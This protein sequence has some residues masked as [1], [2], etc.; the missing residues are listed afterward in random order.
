MYGDY[1]IRGYQNIFS[2]L[3]ICVRSRNCHNISERRSDSGRLTVLSRR[4]KKICCRTTAVPPDYEDDKSQ[5]QDYAESIKVK[6]IEDALNVTCY[7]NV[8]SVW[9]NLIMELWKFF[10]Q[11]SSEITVQ[12][13]C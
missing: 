7:G 9:R 2:S 4:A 3:G 8:E 12:K 10:G 13:S 1:S 6:K 5:G 11:N